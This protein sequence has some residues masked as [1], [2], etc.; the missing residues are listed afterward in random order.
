MEVSVDFFDVVF[1]DLALSEVESVFA[2][3][4]AKF[5]IASTGEFGTALKAV[6]FFIVPK[7]PIAFSLLYRINAK[8]GKNLSKKYQANG[9]IPGRNYGVYRGPKNFS[10][11]FRNILKTGC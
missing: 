4:A 9:G 2:S 10:G 7:N 8:I 1:G 5:F 6:F 3:Y 11:R